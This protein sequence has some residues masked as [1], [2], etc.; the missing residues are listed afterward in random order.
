MSQEQRDRFRGARSRRSTT[1]SEVGDGHGTAFG[2][3]GCQLTDAHPY[4]GL[5]PAPPDGDR[6]E[7]QIRIR[8]D[9]GEEPHPCGEA[10]LGHD[11][12]ERR[13]RGSAADDVGHGADEAAAVGQRNVDLERARGAE[14]TLRAASAMATA[15]AVAARSSTCVPSA[16]GGR[17]P[18]AT[19]AAATPSGSPPARSAVSIRSPMLQAA[20]WSSSMLRRSGGRSSSP[21]RREPEPLAEERLGRVLDEPDEVVEADRESR[22]A[23]AAPRRNGPGTTSGPS[24]ARAPA[25]WCGSKPHGPSTPSA[26]LVK[27]RGSSRL[28]G[29]VPDDDVAGAT[30]RAGTGAGRVDDVE[31]LVHQTPGG[32]TSL[33]RWVAPT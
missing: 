12:R 15:F 1:F 17:S 21:P 6:C 16:P 32:S 2:W 13:R 18:R 27:Q 28:E 3:R 30:G 7:R 24:E 10:A 11:L 19:S 14:D 9:G 8:G 5:V 29:V 31:E 25:S 33:V 4:H 20:R 23:G 26:P 22:R